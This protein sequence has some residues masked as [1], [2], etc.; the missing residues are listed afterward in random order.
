MTM[1]RAIKSKKYTSSMSKY[2]TSLKTMSNLLNK[3]DT[4]GTKLKLIS[5]K[6]NRL[7]L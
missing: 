5:L 6:S 1:N 3:R 4:N 2:V 7:K